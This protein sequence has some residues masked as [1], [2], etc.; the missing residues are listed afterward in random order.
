MSN[1]VAPHA[2]T[3]AGLLTRTRTCGLRRSSPLN[4]KGKARATELAEV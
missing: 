4:F 1:T 2:R 3:V